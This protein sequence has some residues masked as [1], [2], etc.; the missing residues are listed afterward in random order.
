MKLL[1]RTGA[2]CAE[3]GLDIPIVMAPMAGACP[4]Q[5]AAAVSNAGGLGS[6]G[7]LL[8]DAEQIAQWA[9]DFRTQSNGAFMLNNWIPDPEPER[10]AAHEQAV[11]AFLS[12]FGPEVSAD[13]ADIAQLSFEAQAKAMLAARPHIISSIMGLY[14]AEFVKQMKERKIKWFA[15][16]TSLT[17]A[18]LAEQAG[19]DALVVQGAEAGGHRG[20][21]KSDY[22]SAAGLI[23]LIPV[24]S[25]AVELPLIATGGISDSRTIAAAL[26]LG[27]SAVQIGTGL[28]RTPEASITAVWADE[29]GKTRP[30]DTIIT[31]YFS[32]KPGRAI[33]NAYTD[34]A[35][36][37]NSPKAAPYPVQRAL[38]Q[39]MRS[40]A[41]QENNM[42]GIQ[43]WAGQSAMLAQPIP[44]QQLVTTLWSEVEEQIGGMSG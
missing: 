11:A 14:D 32:G 40:K 3:F 28:L 24:I 17:E 1:D 16:V 5:L 23:S 41:A 19:A 43:G 37:K 36:D 7:A 39:P 31:P 27:A 4:A 29:I 12:R 18:L 21:F 34:A 8:M 2:F 35:M 10:N 6:C 38:T 22:D 13:A 30:E 20:N 33:R 15:T 42:D 9:E 44:A 25:D 26:M